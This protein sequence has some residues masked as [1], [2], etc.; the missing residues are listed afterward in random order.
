LS[1]GFAFEKAVIRQGVL[2]DY[3]Q[4]T[5]YGNY[6]GSQKDMADM[7]AFQQSII[8]KVLQMLCLFLK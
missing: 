7:I 3:A 1:C 4:R 6:I 8:L 2:Y 5:I